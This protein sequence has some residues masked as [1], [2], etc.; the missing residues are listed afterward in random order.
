MIDRLF[1][2]PIRQHAHSP[3]VRR[4]NQISRNWVRV[5]FA[6]LR[7]KVTWKPLYHQTCSIPAFSETTDAAV[8]IAVTNSKQ[9]E[10]RR[11]PIHRPVEIIRKYTWVCRSTNLQTRSVSVDG[12]Y[13]ACKAAVF[14]RGEEQVEIEQRSNWP[15]YWT[16]ERKGNWGDKN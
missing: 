6:C 1:Q 10:S 15:P 11:K 7:F 8:A 4:T 3:S 9:R 12:L 5:W 2:N 16:R 13:L 14:F